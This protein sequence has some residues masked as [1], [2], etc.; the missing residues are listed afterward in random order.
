VSSNRR[1]VVLTLIFCCSGQVAGQGVATPATDTSQ[2]IVAWLRANAVPLG[3]VE[4]GRGSSD[5]NALK[6]TLKD[7]RI[8]GLGEVT[9]GGREIVRVK[10]RLVEFLVT[11]MGFTAFALEAA[12]S[13]AE[14]IN[15]YVLFGKGDRASALTSQGYVAHDSEEFAEMLEWLRRY[16]ST[17]PA[18][19]KVRFYGL[20]LFRNDVGRAKVLEFV[21]RVLPEDEAPADSAF[22]ALA[23]EEA[24]WPAWDTANVA[25][26]R[27][28]LEVLS[29]HL[30]AGETELPERATRAEFDRMLQYIEVMKQAALLKGRSQPMADNL[31]YLI[32]HERPGTKL[33]IW[34]HNAHVATST[35]NPNVGPD[36]YNLGYLLRRQFGRGYYALATEFDHG[37]YRSRITTPPG[38]FKE[39][40]LSSAPTGSIPWQLAQSAVGDFFVDL[41]AA[42]SDDLVWRWLHSPRPA[43]NINWA[44]QDSSRVF[45][46]RNVGALYDGIVFLREITSTHPTA[47]AA[48]IVAQRIGF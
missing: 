8:V 24:K 23:A 27:P 1:R 21:H 3:H 25:R 17:A 26:I 36:S 31:R 14:P 4:P 48:K 15:D 38:D 33:V 41:R 11:Q 19:K 5:L 2:A 42:R 13:D 43:H 37:S 34:A 30:V 16:N 12:F 22:R 39:G 9:H 18:A 47:N 20:D 7:V 29:N 10:H 28:R 35:P 6:K 40:V 46:R 44:Y 45:A 32:D